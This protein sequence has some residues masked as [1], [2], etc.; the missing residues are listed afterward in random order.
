MIFLDGGAKDSKSVQATFT[1]A[2]GNL[3]LLNLMATKTLIWLRSGTS[4]TSIP[5]TVDSYTTI[6]IL[7]IYELIFAKDISDRFISY[8][9]MEKESNNPF[10]EYLTELKI[11]EKTYRYF[12]YN[13][14]ND[15]RI[16]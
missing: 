14:L 3:R 10:N 15:P 8:Y 1:I 13:K 2:D 16:A 11:G 12:D 6:T 7:L 9:K 5:S 4:T